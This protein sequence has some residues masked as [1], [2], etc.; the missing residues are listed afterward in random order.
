MSHNRVNG[1]GVALAYMERTQWT[2]HKRGSI[3][4][5]FPFPYPIH[6]H[7]HSPAEHVRRQLDLLFQ[8]SQF[9]T[10]VPQI[11]AEMVNTLGIK[12]C[13]ELNIVKKKLFLKR[14]G[15]TVSRFLSIYIF[16]IL[17]IKWFLKKYALL[18]ALNFI[19]FS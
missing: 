7:S 2:C 10:R 13:L 17:S 3:P 15:T 14:S 5:P 19:F 9:S 4:F 11:V 12:P 8:E 6:S 18:F 16:F 1:V